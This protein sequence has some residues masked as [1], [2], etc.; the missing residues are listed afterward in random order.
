MNILHYR[1]SMTSD[2]V[3]SSVESLIEKRHC[4]GKPNFTGTKNVRSER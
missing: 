4:F 1:T 3:I 2:G